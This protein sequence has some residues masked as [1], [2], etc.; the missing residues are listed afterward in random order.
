MRTIVAAAVFLAPLMAAERQALRENWFLQ[1]S[2]KIREKGSVISRLDYVP[3]GW[4]K[5]TVPTTVLAA[6]VANG[7]YP[8]PYYGL[9]LKSIPGF[10]EGRWLV[11]PVDSPFRPAWWFRTEF[12]LP[13]TYRGKYLRLHLD[14][15]NYQ[16]NVWLNGR[17][18]ADAAGVV[19]MFRRFEFPIDAHARIGEKN[20]LAVEII[21][22]GLLPNRTYGTKQIQATT[23][24]DDH[25]P[26]PPDMNMGIWQ[27]VYI[28]VSGPV[29]L[30]H[31]C[32]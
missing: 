19:G 5:T 10:K 26:Q 23:G 15:I 4:Y 32:G 27:D 13:P 2:A 20:C 3:V 8:D 28:T 16:A 1:S 12:E 31:P 11:M 18:V 22:P 14:G 6:L 29:I 17:K 9:N 25:N 7:V 24:W 21:P 30:R